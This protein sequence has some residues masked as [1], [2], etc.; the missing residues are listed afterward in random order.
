MYLTS[1]ENLRQIYERCGC[2]LN[3]VQ[4]AS[5]QTPARSYA[6]R[7]KRLDPIDGNSPYPFYVLDMTA[8]GGYCQDFQGSQCF[9]VLQYQERLKFLKQSLVLR[10]TLNSKMPNLTADC[11]LLGR[12]FVEIPSNFKAVVCQE[13]SYGIKNLS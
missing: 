2:V 8:P 3:R 1:L 13:L 5:V 6:S 9:H 11:M 10:G 7:V 12:A 4:V